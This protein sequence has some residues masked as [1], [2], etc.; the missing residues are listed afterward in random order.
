LQL[1]I[2]LKESHKPSFQEK[3][4]GSGGSNIQSNKNKSITK[5]KGKKTTPLEILKFQMMWP[6][7]I[8]RSQL[9]SGILLT[10]MKDLKGD[11]LVNTLTFC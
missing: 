9:Q 4:A 10:F 5:G 1:E 3:L 8:M 6:W 11:T 2:E 7:W